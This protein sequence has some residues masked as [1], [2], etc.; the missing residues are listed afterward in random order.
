MHLSIA[1]GTLYLNQAQKTKAETVQRIVYVNGQYVPESEAKVSIFDRAFLFADAVYEVT[2][3]LDGK[4]VDFDAHLRRLRRSLNEI[5]LPVDLSDEQL[6]TM[7]RELLEHNRL[8][9]GMIYMQIS[10]GAAERSFTFPANP[11]PVC[12]AFTQEKSMIDDPQALSGISVICIEDIRWKRCDIKTVSLLAASLC[13]N[14]AMKAGADDAWMTSAGQI[15]EGTSNN[16]FIVNKDKEII[17]RSL[18]NDILPGIT[19]SCVLELAAQENLKL[20]E[21]PFDISEAHE[22]S[23]A[24]ITS[25]SAFVMPVVTIDGNK[26]GDGTPGALCK[27][28]RELYINN[29]KARAI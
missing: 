4:L 20:K 19:R 7:H 17:T 21:R 22:A 29:A 5:S 23:E 28:L 3:V 9:E 11:S 12:V 1:C 6:L 10:R 8:D 13:K 2:A 16:A 25:A 26:I 27:R 15:T 18:G 24:F 14:E